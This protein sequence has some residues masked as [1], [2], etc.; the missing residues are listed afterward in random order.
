MCAMAASW[1]Q[2]TMGE[3]EAISNSLNS[4]YKSSQRW[5]QVSSSVWNFD[6]TRHTVSRARISLFLHTNAIV[7]PN[8]ELVMP[9]LPSF[10][11]VG[12]AWKVSDKLF[13]EHVS[14]EKQCLIAWMVFHSYTRVII[15]NCLWIGIVYGEMSCFGT[16]HRCCRSTS[17]HFGTSY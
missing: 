15:Y 2:P 13:R 17:W 10:V 9:K 1:I 5:A 8:N 11:R 6:P 12:L 4:K 14:D 16:I 3:D 7:I